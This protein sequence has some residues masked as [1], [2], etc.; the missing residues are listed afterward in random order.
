MPANNLT[1]RPLSGRVAVISGASRGIGLSCACHLAA[2]GADIM[3][4]AAHSARLQAAAQDVHEAGAGKVHFYAGDLRTLE[5]CRNA[6]AAHFGHFDRCDIFI[7]SA[8][9]TRGGVFPEQDD[10]DY[11]DG[12][13]LKFHAGVRLAR[14]FWPA[15]RSARGT[16]VMINGTASRTPSKGFLVGGAVNAALANF[17]KGLAEQ[18]LADDVN[19]NWINPGLTETDRLTTLFGTRAQEENKTINE[20]RDERIEQE[21]I[22]RIG[23]PEDIAALAA[24]L[25]LPQARH[26]HGAGITVDGGATRG[27]F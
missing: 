27:Y 19:V 25:C 23:Q 12:F 8:G 20:I 11:I 16:I 14:L 17:T 15:L 7:H 6:H 10:A 13:A 3:L 22:R 9:A 24:F 18:G 2:A 5:G 26:I 4:L 21:G 1:S